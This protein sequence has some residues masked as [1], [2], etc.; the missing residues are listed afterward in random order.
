[1]KRQAF[2]EIAKRFVGYLK[3]ADFNQVFKFTL[4]DGCADFEY[5][6][7]MVSEFDNWIFVT[8]MYG[9][10]SGKTVSVLTFENFEGAKSEDWDEE[11][12]AITD[13]LTK[14]HEGF[15]V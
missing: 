14:N 4:N 6:I 12:D 10:D 1:M 7:K 5:G 3:E 13:Y 2:E 9:D 15:L 11:L 8:S